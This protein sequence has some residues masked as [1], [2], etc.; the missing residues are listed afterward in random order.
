MASI[1]CVTNGLPGLLYTSL[2]LARRLAA[3]GH[4]LTYASFPEARATVEDHGIEFLELAPSRYEAFL[5]TDAEHGLWRRLR[6]I[7]RRRE[8]A[9]AATGVDGFVRDLR[10]VAPDLVLI[11]GELHE[12]IVAASVTGVPIALLN[13]FVSIWRHP[14]LPPPHRMVLPGVGLAGTRLGCALLW[15]ELRLKKARRA[16]A[17]SVGRIGCDRLSL[18]RR[19]ARTSGFDLRA[20]TDRSQ[21]PIPLTYRRLPVLSLHAREFEF[22]QGA[23]ARVHFVGPMVSEHRIDRRT[24]AEDRQRL[25]RIFDRR[26]AGEG[27]RTLVYAGFGSFFSSDVGLVRRLVEGV[28]E[29]DRELIVSL[30][31]RIDPATLGPLPEG[32][33]AFAW[34]PQAELL[35]HV[36]AAVI[37]GGINTIDEC[38]LAGVPMLVYCGFETDMGGS[39]ARLVH[40]GL[41]IAGDRRRD[42]PAAIR[43]HL[44]RLL[45]ESRFTETVRRFQASY[46]AYAEQR[47][48]EHT[49]ATLLSSGGGR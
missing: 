41:G 1:L 48:A 30:G 33:H 34:V 37:H 25:Q 4:Q 15:L 45:H 8:R 13:T 40:H 46:A 16:W 39:T 44:D 20:E 27:E 9:A 14:G 42:D 17:H 6:T 43:A 28:V 10:T 26:R 18:L 38:V 5:A 19:L 23:P 29:A 22:R 35:R 47:V 7:E 3:D 49:V 12:H 21:W 24:T 31:G 36:D 11:D 2:E 32:T